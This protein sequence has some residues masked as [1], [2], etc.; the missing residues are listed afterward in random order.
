[1]I[2]KLNSIEKSMSNVIPTAHAKDFVD[3]PA[4]L[5]LPVL[6]LTLMGAML[7]FF[8]VDVGQVVADDQLRLRDICRLKGQEENTLQGLGLVVGLKGTGDDKLKPTARALARMMQLMGSN[9]TTDSQGFPKLDEIEKAGNVAL[10]FVTAVIPPAG[11]QQGDTMNCTISAL[12]AKSLDGGILMLTPLLGP[13]A[14][15]PTVYALAQG[16]ITIAN[17][18]TPTNGTIH[19]GCK[20]EATIR[21]EFIEN[22]KVTLILDS[23]VSGFSTVQNIEDEINTLNRNGLS[24]FSGNKADPSAKDSDQLMIAQAIDPLH[25]EVTIPRF[26]RDT[27]VKFVSLLMDLPLPYVQSKKRVVINEREGVVV[28]GEDV[29]LSPVAIT[30]KN[31]A[32][33]ARPGKGGFVAFDTD[34]GNQPRAK[35][36][37]L[38]D[39]L[40]ALEV[41]TNDVIAII[42]ALKRQG[43]LYGELVVQ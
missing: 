18:A 2:S 27:P 8:M 38:T 17:P 1:M 40:N 31:L 15:R 23:D 14:D 3:S 43:V 35:L 33:E 20:M 36:K 10:V 42:K 21:N 24:G 13:R 5:Q 37:N 7:T 6:L 11:A 34:N 25:I 16:P 12:S 28:I 4:V 19:R 22:D 41:P 30:H 26:Y 9:I 29:L 32:I 39:A